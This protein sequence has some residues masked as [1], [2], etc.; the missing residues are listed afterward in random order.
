MTVFFRNGNL[1]DKK[2]EALSPSS[3]RNQQSFHGVFCVAPEF[4]TWR[5]NRGGGI[6]H[7]A[8]EAWRRNSQHPCVTVILVATGLKIY[9]RLSHDVFVLT[10]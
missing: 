3:L 8:A 4:T 10:I 5:R 1:I 9:I 7:V 2:E 6:Q